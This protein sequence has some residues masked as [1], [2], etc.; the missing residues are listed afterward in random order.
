L[1]YLLDA[2]ALLAW[3]NEEKGKGYEAVDA[4]L[5]RART[6]EITICMS[7]INLTEVYY[8]L[9]RDMGAEM[10]GKIMRD[11]ED[12]PIHIIENVTGAVYREAARFKAAYSLSLADVFLCATAQS[13][14]AVVV[15]KDKEIA[16]AEQSEGLSVFWIT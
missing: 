16:A 7:I 15:T 6:G 9:I 11:A 13:L 5:D 14:S 4:L 1:I 2:C 12:L 8:G 3:I 10:A